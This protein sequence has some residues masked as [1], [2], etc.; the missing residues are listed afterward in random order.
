MDGRT[1]RTRLSPVLLVAG[2]YSGSF[3]RVVADDGGG[4]TEAIK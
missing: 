4:W 1:Q 2:E 3:G